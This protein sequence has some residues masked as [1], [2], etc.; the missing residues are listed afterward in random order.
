MVSNIA[1]L[2][3]LFTEFVLETG[4]IVF[5][6]VCRNAKLNS[7]VHLKT[8][9]VRFNR[10]CICSKHKLFLFNGLWEIWDNIKHIYTVCY[11]L[12]I[13]IHFLFCVHVEL[14][15]FRFSESVNLSSINKHWQTRSHTILMTIFEEEKYPHREILLS[16]ILNRSSFWKKTP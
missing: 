7:H 1:L 12:C 15:F 11:N 13:K 4:R 8:K 3:N 16:D 10:T 9:Y 6:F 2:I 5:S 14:Y